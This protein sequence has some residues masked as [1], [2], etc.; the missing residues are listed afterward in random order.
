MILTTRYHYERG[1][2]WVQGRRV[3]VGGWNFNLV[4]DFLLKLFHYVYVAFQGAELLSE[5][6]VKRVS[7][8][9]KASRLS[10][11]FQMLCQNNFKSFE[12]IN[13]WIIQECSNRWLIEKMNASFHRNTGWSEWAEEVNFHFVLTSLQNFSWWV[14]LIVPMHPSL[15][16]AFASWRTFAATRSTRRVR[17]RVT[18]CA[19]AAIVTAVSQNQE[20]ILQWLLGRSAADMSNSPRMLPAVTGRVVTLASAIKNSSQQKTVRP[21]VSSSD[22]GLRNVSSGCCSALRTLRTMD[23]ARSFD[24]LFTQRRLSQNNLPRPL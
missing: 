11:T 7:G 24:V 12:F 21:E 3:W 2:S 20:R 4:F 15:S 23:Q 6:I 10:F 14:F 1:S 19:A 22:F 8:V 9:L 17:R 18:P 5:E 13:N 16:T